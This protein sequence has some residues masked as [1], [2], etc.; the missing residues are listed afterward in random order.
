VPLPLPPSLSSVVP[1]AVALSGAATSAPSTV[2]RHIRRM[3]RVRTCGML[4]P[5]LKVDVLFIVFSRFE[6]MS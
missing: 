2:S 5:P 6:R 1:H 3:E 4:P